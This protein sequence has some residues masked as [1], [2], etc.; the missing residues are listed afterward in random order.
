MKYCTIGT[1]PDSGKGKRKCCEQCKRG[2]DIPEKFPH[3]GGHCAKG[4]FFLCAAEIIADRQTIYFEAYLW[5]LVY[6][7]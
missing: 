1:I 4:T 3:S 5:Y 2:H 6:G 7:K